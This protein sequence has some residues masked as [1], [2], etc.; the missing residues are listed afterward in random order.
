MDFIIGINNIKKPLLLRDAYL[1][2]AIFIGARLRLMSC[3]ASGRSIPTFRPTKNSDQE[4][5][6]FFGRGGRN[7]THASG[8]G[9]RCTTIIRRPLETKET[10]AT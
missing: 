1:A 2:G 10:K 6:E 9:D 5:S 4:W 8:F 3:L 7:R